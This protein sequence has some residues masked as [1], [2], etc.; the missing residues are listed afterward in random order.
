MPVKRLTPDEH[1]SIIE[2]KLQCVSVR[3]I[4]REV[5]CNANSVQRVWNKYLQQRVSDRQ[6]ETAIQVENLL[7]RLER[8]AAD[9]R[10]GFQRAVKDADP[11]SA[12]RFLE[13][14]R[15]ALVE[16]S[17]LG[18]VRDDEPRQVAAVTKGVV[19]AVWEAAQQL[20]PQQRDEF[21]RLASEKLS[22]L[23]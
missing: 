1:D 19:D 10:Q 11:S 3:Q 18:P 5:G 15:K 8:N 22:A 7:A 16:L 9:G 23:D 21:L 14:E 13:S 6:S 2:L 12:S 4:A 17:K 20:P